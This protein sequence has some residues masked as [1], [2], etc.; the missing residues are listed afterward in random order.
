MNC[1]EFNIKLGTIHDPEKMPEE[2][3]RHME[4][5]TSCREACDQT[6]ALFDFINSE[7]KAEPSP[8][9]TTRIMAKI[10]HPAPAPWFARPAVVSIM[11]VALM[12]LGFFTANFTDR[13]QEKTQGSSEVIASEYY[14]TEN[15]GS[16]LEEIW[17]ND[18]DYE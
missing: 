7:K 16:E 13:Q 18:Y 12:V 3:V 10:Q 9:I 14:F 15:P 2:M 8:F 4:Q 1:K 6:R 5:C 17:L 11:S